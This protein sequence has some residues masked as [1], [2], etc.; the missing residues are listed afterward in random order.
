MRIYR[1]RKFP[2]GL[3]LLILAIII[4]AFNPKT[5]LSLKEFTFGIMAKPFAA[6]KGVKTYFVHARHLSEENLHLKE[7]LGALSVALARMKEISRENERLRDLL[8]FEKNLPY[9]VIAARVIAR[10][11]TD[12]RGVIII[13]KGKTHGITE[14]MPCATVKGFI[15]SVGEASAASSK[16]MLITDP[17]SKI[18]VVLE[19]SRES[20]LLTGS[21]HGECKVIYLSL[22]SKIKKGERVLTAGFSQTVPKGLAIGKVTATGVE[23][24]NLYKFAI[25]EPFEDMG[26]IE[27]VLCIDAGE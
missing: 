3:F 8:D 12:W 21:P 1:I 26:K 2:A 4:I 9:T 25:V 7:R 24:P 19:G 27:E 18:G 6:L 20:G 5:F 14:G 10:D 22:D 17:N 23:K 11:P 16:I 15:G 13:D